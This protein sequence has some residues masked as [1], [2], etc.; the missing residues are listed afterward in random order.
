MNTTKASPH[1]TDR[2]TAAVVGVLFILGTVPGP[3]EPAPYAKHCKCSGSSDCDLHQCRPD[4]H[5][6]GD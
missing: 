4:D 1:G 5:L 6:H 2:K 3:T